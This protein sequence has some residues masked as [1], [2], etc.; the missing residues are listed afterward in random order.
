MRKLR[1]IYQIRY[2]HIII[3]IAL[4]VSCGQQKPLSTL[5][6][7][8]V[9]GMCIDSAATYTRK[10]DIQRAMTFLKYAERLMTDIS[11]DSLRY[12]IYQYIAIM[13]GN[14]GSP[15]LALH[16]HEK[17]LRH[18]KKAKSAGFIVDALLDKAHTFQN[19]DIADS[20]W[21]AIK[22]AHIYYPRVDENR[23][24]EIMYH[25]AEHDLTENQTEH[26]EAHAYKAA[27]L[28]RDSLALSNALS[29]LCR[30]YIAQ[31]YEDKAN[32]IL[33][34]TPSGNSRMSEYNRLLTEV[35]ILE[36]RGDYKT[37]LEK[38]K[39]LKSLGDSLNSSTNRTEIV[40]MQAQYDQAVS[41]NEN[42]KNQLR[43][44]WTIIALASAI[45]GIWYWYR[46]K[47]SHIFENYRTRIEEIRGEMELS[48]CSKDATIEEMKEHIDKK[49][50]ELNK[51]RKK[52][53]KQGKISETADSIDKIKLGTDVL[54]TI[55]H[56]GNISQYGRREQKAVMEV[57]QIIDNGLSAVFSEESPT[58][59]PKET[60]YLI[61]EYNGIDD[62]RK[63]ISF[64]C[65]EQA[66]RSTKSRLGKKL[67]IS[68]ILQRNTD[69][70]STDYET[71]EKATESTR[72]RERHGTTAL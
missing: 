16:Y 35:C 8:K 55:L 15:N 5:K 47:M 1:I 37:A 18:A 22:Q 68:K 50:E 3:C 44:T 69:I 61:M 20:A 11:N 49:A 31:G 6:A 39:R 29:L 9:A 13:N 71:V 57:L 64:C 56:N 53:Q 66:I 24:S 4:S 72:N 67:D 32:V 26:A 65:S 42:A 38:Y 25:I 70:T 43:L 34:M 30:I 33:G 41:D 21:A 54:Y 48:L 27:T 45:G 59:T 10:Q 52:L 46:R 14:N 58:L 36:K 17:A 7:E 40:R 62:T 2:I 19:M 63:S 12:R 23:K 60:F 28:A 51:L